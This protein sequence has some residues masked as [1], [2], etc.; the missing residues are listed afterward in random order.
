M[1]QILYPT[2]YILTQLAWWVLEQQPTLQQYY[3]LCFSVLRGWQSWLL[4]MYWTTV[5]VRIAIYHAA[6]WLRSHESNQPH[7]DVCWIFIVSGCRHSYKMHS[8]LKSQVINSTIQRYWCTNMY[9]QKKHCFWWLTQ[10]FIEE[11]E[12]TYL[13]TA[14][15]SSLYRAATRVTLLG[16]PRYWS[17]LSI[18]EALSPSEFPTFIKLPGAVEEFIY[19]EWSIEQDMISLLCFLIGSHFPTRMLSTDWSKITI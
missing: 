16:L 13:Y 4:F 5:R 12:P 15:S 3:G 17:I 9:L 19:I 11:P 2:S 18:L 7:Q 6:Y 10:A 8:F 14:K 1:S